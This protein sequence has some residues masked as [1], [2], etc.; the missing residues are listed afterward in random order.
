MKKLLIGILVLSL[1]A[2]IFSIMQH[3]K[4][5]EN[6]TPLTQL[7]DVKAVDKKTGME[8]FADKLNEVAPSVYQNK[9]HFLIQ[10]WDT[11]TGSSDGQKAG[12]KTLDSMANKYKNKSIGFIF[13]SEM[14]QNAIETYQKNHN[15][16][17]KNF[18]FLPRAHDFISSIC[19][20]KKL[21]FKQH[22]AQFIIDKKGDIVYYKNTPFID[23]A[24]DSL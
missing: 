13:V 23:V 22:P 4:R 19:V 5:N 24:K 17:F 16:Y 9:N 7:Y 15:F 18:I 10:T 12:M 20:Q 11:L 21:K 2:N 6:Y 14:S 1:L 8:F 3:I